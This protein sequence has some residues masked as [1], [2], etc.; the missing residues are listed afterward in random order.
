MILATRLCMHLVPCRP[1][2]LNFPR[3]RR[4]AAAAST[5]ARRRPA[6]TRRARASPRRRSCSALPRQG[7]P[8]CPTRHRPHGTALMAPRDGRGVS[9]CSALPPHFRG[10]H[11]SP[12][13]PPA[14]P[15]LALTCC[16]CLCLCLCPPPQPTS[17]QQ[18]SEDAPPFDGRTTARESWQQWQ[19]EGRRPLSSQWEWEHAARPPPLSLPS[20]RRRPRVAPRRTY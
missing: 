11:S 1:G 19:G 8:P 20:P 9:C 6:R 5:A 4:R 10:P 13:R 12:A 16:L 14:P 18:P 17:Q 3:R 2:R 15:C 7:A